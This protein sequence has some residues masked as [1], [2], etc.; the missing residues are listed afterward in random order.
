MLDA[1]HNI[2]DARGRKEFPASELLSFRKRAADA[3]TARYLDLGEGAAVIEFHH[4]LRLEGEPVIY[5]RVVVPR[6]VFPAFDEKLLRDRDVTIFGLYQTRFGVTVTR[7]EEWI[8]AKAA[9]PEAARH[10]NLKRG[11]PVLAV[12]RVAQTYDGTPVEYRER[13]VDT[14]H[15]AYFNILG[16]DARRK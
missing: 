5:D 2:V 14:A 16:M 13:Y 11:A 8:R 3:E 15:H 10:L 1:F 4:L 9:P 6:A 12:E 7:L